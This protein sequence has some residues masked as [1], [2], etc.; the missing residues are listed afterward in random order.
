MFVNVAVASVLFEPI[1]VID[2][3]VAI[4]IVMFELT[5]MNACI[6]VYTRKHSLMLDPR[7]NNVFSYDCIVNLCMY[8]S[9]THKKPLNMSLPCHQL[10][11]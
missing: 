5:V 6:H 1:M 7:K 2:I 9:K 11:R 4:A 3:Q 10:N 8:Q